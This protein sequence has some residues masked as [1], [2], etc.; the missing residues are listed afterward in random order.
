[1]KPISFSSGI[2]SSNVVVENVETVEGACLQLPLSTVAAAK[3]AAHVLGSTTGIRRTV[4]QG[5]SRIHLGSR[6]QLPHICIRLSFP[7]SESL[8]AELLA[9]PRQLVVS[10]L[11]TNVL[12]AVLGCL[13]PI[14]LD[15]ALGYEYRGGSTV[16]QH[17]SCGATL[18]T[19]TDFIR[20]REQWT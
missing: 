12:V 10:Q 8:S 15:P 9:P 6:R 16:Q 19:N 4:F 5:C 20:Y 17:A 11:D 1:M 14:L 18:I 7:K 13:K 2:T 3:A